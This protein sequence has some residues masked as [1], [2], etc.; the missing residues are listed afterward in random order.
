MSLHR[1]SFLRAW[2]AGLMIGLALLSGCTAWKVVPP[3]ADPAGAAAGRDR[4]RLTLVDQRQVVVWRPYVEGDSLRGFDREPEPYEFRPELAWSLQRL[5]VSYALRDIRRWETRQSDPTRTAYLVVGA[6]LV[7][8]VIVASIVEATRDEPPPSYHSNYDDFVISCPLIYSWD[9]SGWRLDSGT[10]GGA[11]FPGL[12]R[13]DVDNLLFAQPVAGS[14]GPEGEAALPAGGAARPGG[15][16]LLFRLKDIAPETEYVDAFSLLAVDHDPSVSIAPGCDGTIHTVGAVAPPLSARDFRGADALERV[17]S[18]DGWGWESSPS[19]RDPSKESDIRDG[20]EIEFARPAGAATARLVIDG[21]NTEWAALLMGEY[22]RAHGREADAWYD[23]LIADPD[24]ARQVGGRLAREGFLSVSVWSGG[25]W[26]PQGLVMEAGPEVSKRQVF[27]L[28][29][30]AVTGESVK[31]RLESV[32]LFW[33]IDAVGLDGSAER[34]VRVREAAPARAVSRTGADIRAS[35]AAVDGEY[36]VMEPGDSAEVEFAAPP[37]EP[38]LT[39]SWLA[40]TTGW[41]RIHG[42]KSGEPQRELL[43]RVEAEQHGISRIS[44]EMMNAALEA[45]RAAAET[46][47]PPGR[48]RP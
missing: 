46:R 31:V 22:V 36:F 28:D 48:Q 23:S 14:S 2:S 12:A 38:G 30:S 5:K 17:I 39:R 33:W 29:L 3:Q 9:G 40:K 8:A 1:E 32:P 15:S 41:Y 13:T 25:A 44:V 7:A 4:V 11:I 18:V 6:G 34:A 27:P 24:R 45:L 20:L 16:R 19:G 42:S 35:L 37:V 10:F 26:R 47:V 21:S 43:A